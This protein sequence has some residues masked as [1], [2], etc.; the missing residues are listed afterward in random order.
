MLLLITIL[1]WYAHLYI[2]LTLF[3]QTDK[4]PEKL[5]RTKS[6]IMFLVILTMTGI[7]AVL[8]EFYEEEWTQFLICVVAI[9]LI[10]KVFYDVFFTNKY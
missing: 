7:L 8:Y 9:Y 4:F 6:F 3:G 2:I 1:I 5:S 10:V